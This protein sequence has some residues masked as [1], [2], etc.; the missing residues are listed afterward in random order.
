MRRTEGTQKTMRWIEMQLIADKPTSVLRA[1][2]QSVE[3]KDVCERDLLMLRIK[4]NM[5]TDIP[6]N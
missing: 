3:K 1:N 6:E 2:R 4:A 5:A